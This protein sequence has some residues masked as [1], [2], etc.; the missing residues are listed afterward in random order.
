MPELGWI[1]PPNGFM[2]SR[3]AGVMVITILASLG[4]GI[5]LALTLYSVLDPPGPWPG[6]TA[7]V[8]PLPL[9]LWFVWWM[10]RQMKRERRRQLGSAEAD[11]DK[12]SLV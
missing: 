11:S 10:T 2:S 6:L 5:G 12:S 9:M 3:V 7:A 4:L 1:A 8:S